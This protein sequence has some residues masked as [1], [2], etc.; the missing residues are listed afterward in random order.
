MKFCPKCQNFL[1]EKVI[2]N[3][4][5]YKCRICSYEE[6]I[7]ASEENF[8]IDSFNYK[9]ITC[10]DY[11]KLDINLCKDITYPKRKGTKC[12]NKDCDSDEHI[13]IICK[14]NMRFRY[15]CCKCHTYW[16]N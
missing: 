7:K 11:S 1:N 2:D 13:Y 8:R 10:Q 5:K 4:L 3:I 14:G 9:D 12:K 16:T 15:I 6:E